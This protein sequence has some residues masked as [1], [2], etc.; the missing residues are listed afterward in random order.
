MAT[1]RNGYKS[2]LKIIYDSK[3]GNLRDLELKL[4]KSTVRQF[5]AMGFIT[6]APSQN[7]NTWKISDRA[8]RLAEIRFRPYTR[9]EKIRDFCRFKLPRLLFGV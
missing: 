5:E 9:K 1:E 2:P 7:G 3:Y 8:N 4:G 6:N